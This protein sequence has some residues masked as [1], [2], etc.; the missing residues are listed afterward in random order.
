MRA[1]LTQALAGKY[2]FSFVVVD[3]MSRE[4]VCG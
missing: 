3:E 1:K 4:E 2:A